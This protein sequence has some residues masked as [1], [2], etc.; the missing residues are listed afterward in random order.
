MKV[1]GAYI[2]RGIGMIIDTAEERCGSVFADVLDDE[3]GSSGV[4]FDE[5]RD[6]VDEAGDED[7]GAGGGLRDDYTM[8]RV[9][10][11]EAR[12]RVEGKDVQL[13]QLTTG[14]SL[15]SSGQAS[16]SCVSWRRLSCMVS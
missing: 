7:E 9:R 11:F 4:L 6:I 13:S 16:F 8:R 15:L 5:G 12:M 14:R 3:V 1:G 2:V 10:S